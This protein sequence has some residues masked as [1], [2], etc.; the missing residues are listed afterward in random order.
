MRKWLLLAMALLL[1]VVAGCST[2]HVKT[3]DLKHKAQ[4][5]K[6]KMK[7]LA[8]K[9]TD[10]VT[11]S[12]DDKVSFIGGITGNT[13]TI[14]DVAF[15]VTEDTKITDESGKDYPITD[16]EIGSK[17]KASFASALSGT[18]SIKLAN[19]KSLTV[20]TD[21]TSWANGMAADL[22]IETNQATGVSLIVNDVTLKEGYYYVALRIVSPGSDTV[23]NIKIA[24][25]QI[26][27]QQ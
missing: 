20:Y 4:T 17:V 14:G 2:N 6:A 16:L 8:P 27:V 24:P 9:V 26:A 12:P 19:L 22:A 1:L 10:P 13:I 11:Q 15:T 7:P 5:S 21:K 23:K 25:D 3:A 18:G